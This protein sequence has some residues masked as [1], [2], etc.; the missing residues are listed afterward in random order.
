MACHTYTC[1]TP[2]ASLVSATSRFSPPAACSPPPS[3]SPSGLVWNLVFSL[4]PVSRL[5]NLEAINQFW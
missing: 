3:P 2:C 4:I 5:A 1:F